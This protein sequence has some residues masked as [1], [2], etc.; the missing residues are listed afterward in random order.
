M[1]IDYFRVNAMTSVGLELAYKSS[2]RYGLIKFRSLGKNFKFQDICSGF[3]G[4]LHNPIARRASRYDLPIWGVILVYQWGAVPG[5][6][7]ILIARNT[8]SAQ[9]NNFVKVENI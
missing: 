4:F 6:R 9:E 2:T 5:L 8:I 1:G 3:L 7:L